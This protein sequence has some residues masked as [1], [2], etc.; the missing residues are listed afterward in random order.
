MRLS[1]VLDETR[2]G[3]LAAIL[4]R[5]PG[6]YGLPSY[7]VLTKRIFRTEDAARDYYA[8]TIKSRVPSG[9]PVEAPTSGEDTQPTTRTDKAQKPKRKRR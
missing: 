9:K 4:E 8:K 5:I 2:K 3:N 1:F 7:S 6:D